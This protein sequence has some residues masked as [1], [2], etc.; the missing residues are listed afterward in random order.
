MP[1]QTVRPNATVR[2]GTLTATGAAS[3]H[4][5]LSDDSDS[6]YVG[7]STSHHEAGNASRTVVAWAPPSIPAGAKVSACRVRVRAVH[8]TSAG[9]GV[10]V[11]LEQES[12]AAFGTLDIY[13]LPS[14]ITTFVGP[15]RSAA[16]SG[17]EWT[18]ALV[19]AVHA[20]ITSSSSNMRAHELYLDVDYNERPEVAPSIGEATAGVVS[21]TT[22]P[23]VDLGYADPEGDVQAAYEVAVYH[24]AGGGVLGTLVWAS[25]E[26]LSL[27]PQVKVGVDLNNGAYVAQV[28]ARQNW[29]GSKHWSTWKT[30]LWTQDVPLTNTPTVTVTADPDEARMLVEVAGGGGTGAAAEW[31]TVERYGKAGW[32]PVRGG[33]PLVADLA[34]NLFDADTASLEGGMGG[35]IPRSVASAVSRVEV[36]AAH[37]DWALRVEPSTSGTAEAYSSVEAD[38]VPVTAGEQYTAR[39]S[40]RSDAAG[41]YAWMWIQW[42]NASD[43]FISG[44]VA[45]APISSGWQQLAVTRTAPAGAVKARLMLQAGSL[46]AGEAA[47]WDAFAINP[48]A[49]AEFRPPG[50]DRPATLYDYEVPLRGQASYRAR[51]FRDV[52]GTVI[53]SGLWSAVAADEL[54]LKSRWITD[55]EFPDHLHVKVKL[56]DHGRKWEGRDHV[57]LPAD[58]GVAVVESERVVR[59]DDV[60]LWALDS[61]EHEM[62]L[63]LIGMRRTVLFR[64]RRDTLY[65]RLHGG[66]EASQFGPDA[67]N[68]DSVR[69]SMVEVA[70]PPVTG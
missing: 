24:N 3:R 49:D 64:D 60:S 61:A 5:A 63:R 67:A 58:M 19:G 7:G 12:P 65:V 17:V 68:A 36:P 54:A 1:I 57:H 50:T 46:A 18:A 20:G 15:W 29:S 44:D 22:R 70:R 59:F 52:A 6:S 48:G 30:V 11:R 37:G 4:A 55:V 40:V 34:P 9:G 53:A 13:S 33:A 42:I 41:V 66:R 10:G 39:A 62:L 47:L 45:G 16:P 14:S 28:R 56:H 38:G 26:V 51:G 25:G 23:R 43:A 8:A 27:A 69:V 35:W 32:E 2:A 31:F 21:G